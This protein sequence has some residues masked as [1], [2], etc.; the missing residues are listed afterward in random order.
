MF[1]KRTAAV[2]LA[3]LMTAM[4]AACGN[5][6]NTA[7]TTSS[8]SAAAA[9]ETVSS[10]ASS[11][12]AEASSSASSTETS[13]DTV[14]ITDI[15]G[16]TV[17]IPTPENLKRVYATDTN[18]FCMQYILA[19]DSVISTG[20][21][22]TE[23]TEDELPYVMEEMVG[24]GTC[25]T[26]SGQNG[27]LDYEA[28]K[29]ADIQLMIMSCN[30]DSTLESDIED[31]DAMQE[32]LDIP[33]ILLS[34]YPD[35]MGDSFRIL[36]KAL[37]KEEEAEE[38]VAYFDDIVDEVTSV[39]ETIPEDERP[40]LYYAEGKDGLSTEPGDSVRSFVFNTCGCTNVAT[41]EV[42]EG[43]GQSSVSMEAV[44]GWDPEVIV[45]Q[46]YTGAYD[47]ITTSE[48]WASITAVKNGDVFEMP[49]EPFNWADR[50]P[51]VNRYIGLLWLAEELYPEEMNIDLTERTIDYYSKI[52][53]VDIT[54]D[55]VAVLLKN[56]VN[57][58]KAAQ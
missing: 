27:V 28:L 5:S 21:S 8:T 35:T 13:S 34:P 40:T 25:G 14:E 20:S 53:H 22:C 33:V 46:G 37:G 39:V 15:G 10:A 45:V 47:I 9:T 18:V 41:V 55:D 38:I 16:R 24:L 7:S 42:L 12:A 58:K 19:P 51:G 49:T 1:R 50:P 36:G 2:V 54:E 52:Y 3:A 31:A 43:F 57:K 26:L 48:D 11:E 17:T 56:A 4:L 44:L 32:Q 6:G 23:F 29:A 30:P